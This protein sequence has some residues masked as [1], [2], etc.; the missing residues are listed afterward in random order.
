[1]P[2]REITKILVRGTNWLGDAVMTIPA[3]HRLRVSFPHAYITLLAP[4]RAAEV[5][6]GFPDVDEVVVYLR[7]EKGKQAFLDAMRALRKERYD[8]AI[9]FQNAFEAALLSILSGVKVRIGYDTQRRG[10][11]LTHKLQR[12]EQ[13]RNRH[14]TQDYLDLVAV[15]ER[16]C[17]GGEV[18][19]SAGAACL[20]SAT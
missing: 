11:L 17:L 15:A 16:A 19:I 10:V 18:A 5:F 14:Q 1:M 6:I 12:G 9:L 8:V 4:P 3:L 7:K 2:S 20:V 13:H